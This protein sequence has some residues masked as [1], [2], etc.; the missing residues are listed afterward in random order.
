MNRKRFL[1]PFTRCG[2]LLLSIAVWL[3]LTSAQ[4]KPAPPISW[5]EPPASPVPTSVSCQ[6]DVAG[7]ATPIPGVHYWV[8]VHRVDYDGVFVPQAE[9][10][11]DPKSRQFRVVAQ[12]GEK[13]DVGKEFEIALISVSDSTHLALQHYRKEAML[14]GNWKPIEMPQ[15]TSPPMFRTVV[16]AGHDC[17]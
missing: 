2:L 15:T 8:L 7:T 10:K 4:Q 9:A 1:A 13:R 17:N 5:Q 11:V 16:K 12:F 14:S 3:P 6:A